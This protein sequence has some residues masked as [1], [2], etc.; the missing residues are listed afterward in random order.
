MY[1]IYELI[2]ST[3]DLP[4]YVGKTI[5][6][7]GRYAQH[8]SDFSGEFMMVSG[9][10][11]QLLRRGGDFSMNIIYS[12][13][14]EEDADD[15]ER[16][17]VNEYANCYTILNADLFEENKSFYNSRECGVDG[18]YCNRKGCVVCS[19]IKT[20][21]MEQ[22]IISIF[23]EHNGA[24]FRAVVDLCLWRNMGNRLSEQGVNYIKINSDKHTCIVF[25]DYVPYKTREF[26]FVEISC[27]DAV[28]ELTTVPMLFPKYGN[29]S[30]GGTWNLTPAR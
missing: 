4:F 1:Y 7:H 18:L 2:D 25:C 3:T 9:Y 6:P 29:R 10:I 20:H 8:R 26:G 22:R 13:N 24:V 16:A 17:L 30:S 19:E 15:M 14:Y 28:D 12:T 23:E 21:H 11:R 27:R 5:T